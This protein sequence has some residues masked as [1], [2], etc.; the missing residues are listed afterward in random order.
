MKVLPSRV[1][2]KKLAG[3]GSGREG[4][5]GGEGGCGCGGFPNAGLAS[6]FPVL[7]NKAASRKSPE[8][9]LIMILPT[10]DGLP[11]RQENESSGP[12]MMEKNHVYK[13]S[14]DMAQIYRVI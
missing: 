7:Q 9:R 10:C 8:N 12:S 13:D 5:G 1:T 2:L 6:A 3:S 4:W 14:M 11:R